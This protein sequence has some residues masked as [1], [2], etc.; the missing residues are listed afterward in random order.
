MHGGFILQLVSC[1]YCGSS[2]SL[3]PEGD[4]LG[5]TVGTHTDSVK[6]DDSS[7]V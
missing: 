3:V 4:L 7:G 5:L 6:T 1:Y 2:D